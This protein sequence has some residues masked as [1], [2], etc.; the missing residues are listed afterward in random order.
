MS[1][2]SELLGD[3]PVPK[4]GEFSKLSV[5]TNKD[6]VKQRRKRQKLNAEKLARLKFSLMQKLN[7]Y[8]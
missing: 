5:V 3:K 6:N 7:V 4:P 2:A 1:K 8:K